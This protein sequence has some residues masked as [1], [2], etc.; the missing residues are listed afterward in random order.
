MIIDFN[1][2]DE[3]A[4]FNFKGGQG[5][6]DTRNFMDSKNKI[7]KSRLKPGASSGYHMHEQNS[8][9]V[10]VISGTGYFKYDDIEER[11]EA[12]DVHYCPMGHSHA[13]FNDGNADV[14]YLAIVPEHH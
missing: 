4:V 5:E 7:M 14:V 6:L 9:I 13:M 11:F 2:I 10:Y 1:K 8:E 12:G 3:E